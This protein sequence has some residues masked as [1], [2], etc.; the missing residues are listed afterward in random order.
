MCIMA[1]NWLMRGN[2][3]VILLVLLKRK[4]MHV[5]CPNLKGSMVHVSYINAFLSIISEILNSW[6]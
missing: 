3:V 4:H 1:V 2:P 5:E 6:V